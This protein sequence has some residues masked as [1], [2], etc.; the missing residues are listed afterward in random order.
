MPPPFVLQNTVPLPTSDLLFQPATHCSKIDC[1]FLPLKIKK[2]V[3]RGY[4]CSVVS[5]VLVVETQGALFNSQNPRIHSMARETEPG[6]FLKLTTTKFV[7]PNQQALSSVK[8]TV[9]RDKIESNMG[10]HPTL[11]YD[12]HMHMLMCKYPH[13]HVHITQ[14]QTER[15]RYQREGREGGMEEQRNKEMKEGRKDLRPKCCSNT[16]QLCLAG[17]RSWS[18]LFAKRLSVTDQRLPPQPGNK[19]SDEAKQLDA[20]LSIWTGGIPLKQ[21]LF[22]GCLCMFGLG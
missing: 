8:Y 18:P 9:S 4:G 19:H 3:S 10:R 21:M 12:L 6:G 16:C 5:E 20:W 11:T 17:A 7:P 13:Q 2:L 1:E 14:R 15:H 22:V